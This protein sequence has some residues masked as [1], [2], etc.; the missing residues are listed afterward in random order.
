MPIMT[1]LLTTRVSSDALALSRRAVPISASSTRL[2]H[3]SWPMISLVFR[4][5][6]KPWC[7]VEQK[8][9]FTTQPAWL[10]MHSVPR[11]SSGMK[12]VSMA[13][14]CPTSN[15]HLRVP[16]DE[17]CSVLTGRPRCGSARPTGPGTRG[18]VGHGVERIGAALVHP[19]LQ[20][21]GA[22]RLAPLPDEFGQGGAIKPQ[23]IDSFDGFHDLAKLKTITA[24]PRESTAV[25]VDFGEEEGDFDSGRFRSVGAVHGV[26]VDAVG[27][28]GADGARA[29]FLGSVAPIRSRFFWMAS[30]PSSTCTNTGPETMKS[31]RS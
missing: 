9:Q 1:T 6:L 16:S 21:A 2:A 20:L 31:T 19:A 28:I 15:S 11:S 30:S 5:R 14:P 25:D 26:G 24:F 7:P 3:H 22:K 18:Q 12:T 10:E 4:L 23:Q 17:R 8:R 29:A 27:E 13:L